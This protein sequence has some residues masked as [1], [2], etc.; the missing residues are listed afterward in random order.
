[1]KYLSTLI[2]ILALNACITKPLEVDIPQQEPKTVVF[3]QVIPNQIMI[4][5]LSKSFGALDLQEDNGDT[6]STALLDQLLDDN[7]I[8]TIE[9]DGIEDTLFRIEKGLYASINTPQRINT[10]YN[11]KIIND[12]GEHLH[13]SSV[14]L[15]KVDFIT[16][17]PEIVQGEDTTVSI[18]YA[19]EDLPGNNWYMVNYYRKGNQS[20][21]VDIN[22][23][24]EN[25]QNNL[26]RTELLSDATFNGTYTATSEFDR[27]EMSPNDTIA[28]TLSNIS[29]DYF[30]YLDLRKR[31][32]NLFSEITRE[33]ISYPTNVS[34]GYGF[35]NTHYPEIR[36][37]D[38]NNY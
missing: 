17:T 27:F 30:K 4:V 26:I 20:N 19:F 32:G 23:I 38:L 24:F 13:A 8:V 35:F 7:A 9:Y 37:F 21:G 3:S 18:S 14:M 10:L 28:V 25:G 33:P 2:L 34:N 36:I 29:E 15:E 6:L 22:S 31:S 1:M 12:R 5:A 11:L 16:L